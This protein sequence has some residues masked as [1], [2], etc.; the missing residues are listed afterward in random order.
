MVKQ[1]GGIAVGVASDEPECIRIDGW[2]RN[3]LA[4][5]GAD[6][7]VPNYANLDALRTVLFPA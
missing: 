5:V 6:F 3:R 2:K 7:I 1:A 4:G